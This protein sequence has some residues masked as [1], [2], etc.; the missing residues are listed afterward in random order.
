M[1]TEAEWEYAARAG[2]KTSYY[3]E[4]ITEDA[5]VTQYAWYDANSN[6]STHPVALKKL[7]N[8]GLYDMS[9]NLCE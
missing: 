1:P 8:F 3:W 4:D 5:T 6:S 7:N 2:S 9:G